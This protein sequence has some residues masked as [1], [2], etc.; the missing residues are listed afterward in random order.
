VAWTA[1]EVIQAIEVD[2]RGTKWERGGTASLRCACY[3]AGHEPWI[4][5]VDVDFPHPTR[6]Y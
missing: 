6:I 4:V 1:L 2:S 3:A 5:V